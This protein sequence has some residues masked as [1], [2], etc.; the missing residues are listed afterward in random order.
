MVLYYAIYYYHL[1]DPK[2]RRH[3]TGYF[4]LRNRPKEK[5]SPTPSDPML[6]MNGSTHILSYIMTNDIASDSESKMDR[7]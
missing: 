2:F 7:L 6:P 3:T 4:Y 5:K 1:L